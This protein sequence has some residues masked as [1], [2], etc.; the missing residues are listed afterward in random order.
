MKR[1]KHLISLLALCLSLL[2]TLP[3]ISCGSAA[4]LTFEKY[5]YNVHYYTYWLSRFKA[6]F[7]YSYTDVKDSDEY[8]DSVISSDGRTARSCCSTLAGSLEP[9]VRPSKPEM[10]IQWVSATTT[11]GV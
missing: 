11:P 10:R 4:V 8:F 6:S 2:C 3:L 1:K 5:S 7:L 9:S